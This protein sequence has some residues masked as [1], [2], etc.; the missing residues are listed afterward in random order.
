MKFFHVKL[1]TIW[2]DGKA[3][4]RRVREERKKKIREEK[5]SEERS[6]RCEKRWKSRETLCFFNACDSEGRKVGSLKRR[7][8]SHLVRWEIKIARPCGTKQIWKWKNK[9][10]SRPEHF[11][12]LRSK[13]MP[14]GCAAK[15]ISKSNVQTAT[16]TLQL[17]TTTTTTTTTALHHNT[18]SSLWLRWPLQPLQKH[19]S[20]PPFGPSG[21][22][23]CHPCIITT[24]LSYSFLS[25][26]TSATALCGTIGKPTA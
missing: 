11:W 13:K 19:N 5:E 7:V 14:R 2:T 25:F 12:K 4:V 23:P 20:Q 21:D 8:R 17:Q 16:T 10:A 6:S 22:A 15:P 1:P 26:E 3:E 24:H 18:S 9:K